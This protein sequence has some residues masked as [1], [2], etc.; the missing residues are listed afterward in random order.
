MPSPRWW[1]KLWVE[2][3]DDPKMGMMS[4][5]IWRR[6]IEM[7]LRAGELNE[8]GN[9]HST[10]EIT[11]RLR[12]DDVEMIQALRHMEKVGI[13]EHMPDGGWRLMH[14]A[15]RNEALDDVTRQRLS[16][17]AKQNSNAMGHT[18]VTKSDQK[19][20]SESDTESETE[21]E[22]LSLSAPV[23]E[24]L[25]L[26]GL[27]KFPKGSEALLK[28]LADL[29]RENGVEKTLGCAKWVWQK[30]DMTLARAISSMQTAVPGWT[31]D[32]PA[33]KSN[34]NGHHPTN[35]GGNPLADELARRKA[36]RDSNGDRVGS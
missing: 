24:F 15:K 1:I 7:I 10:E 16:R 20:E 19:R 17:K 26:A 11:W 33:P 4:D 21:K 18:P 31:V 5:H 9:I 28:N 8:D 6:T 12:G 23:K 27:K 3:L 13:V 22:S 2:I 32:K 14:F 25:D 30:P 35:A 36:A 34:G 29:I